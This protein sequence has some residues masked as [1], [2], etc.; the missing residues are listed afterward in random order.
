VSPEL[1]ARLLMGAL[2]ALLA[3]GALALDGYLAPWYPCLFLLVVVLGLAAAKELHGLLPEGGRPPLWL[4]LLAVGA[5]LLANWPAHV[6]LWPGGAARAWRDVIAALA[7]GLLLAFFVE[8]AT[9]TGPGGAVQRVASLALLTGYLGLLPSFLAQLRWGEA[10]VAALALAIFVPK[11]GDI[12][13]YFT[14]RA[15]GRHKMTP[16]LS[17]KKTWEGLAGGLTAAV[18]VAV[19]LE[20]L[21]EPR[22][23]GNSLAAAGLGLALGVAGVLGDLAESLIKRD[24]GRKDASQVLPGFGGVL[25][26]VD[27]LLFAAPVA[28]FWLRG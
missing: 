2:L 14:G 12:G 25:D 4:A 9:Y 27:A 10:G 1:R 24:C 22:A 7:G 21:I 8:M 23:L 3:A 28:Y 19:L 13:A 6:G 5:V 26:V 17:P 20:W 11:V 16:V 15:M 18:L